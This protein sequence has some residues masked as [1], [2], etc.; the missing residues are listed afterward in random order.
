LFTLGQIIF[1]EYYSL[2]YRFA[3]IQTRYPRIPKLLTDLRLVLFLFLLDSGVLIACAILSQQYLTV[4]E[5]V[6]P[7]FSR[8]RHQNIFA[9]C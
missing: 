8:Y 6:G 4:P 3:T 9:V 2:L 5:V 7:I 1:F